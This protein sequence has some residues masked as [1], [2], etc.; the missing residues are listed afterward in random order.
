V[1]QMIVNDIARYY[2]AGMIIKSQ[3]KTKIK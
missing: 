1:T 2:G 3:L